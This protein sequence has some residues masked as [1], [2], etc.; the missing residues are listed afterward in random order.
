MALEMGLTAEAVAENLK[1]VE[2]LKTVCTNPFESH[3]CN[4]RWEI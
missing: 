3:F 1:L 2:F 4:R